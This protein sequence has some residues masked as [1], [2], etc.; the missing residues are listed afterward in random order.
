MEKEAI[1]GEDKRE[2]VWKDIKD[3]REKE[4]NKSIFRYIMNNTHKEYIISILYSY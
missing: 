1:K 3:N 2:E 4:E